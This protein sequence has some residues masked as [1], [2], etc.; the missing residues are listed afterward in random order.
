MDTKL[1]AGINPIARNTSPENA[2]YEPTQADRLPRL[3]SR[4]YLSSLTRVIVPAAEFNFTSY[5]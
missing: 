1:Y 5:C 3:I 4:A 2:L